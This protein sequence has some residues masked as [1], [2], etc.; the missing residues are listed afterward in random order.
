MRKGGLSK[1]NAGLLGKVHVSKEAA[2]IYGVRHKSLMP[3]GI[4]YI[5]VSYD[6]NLA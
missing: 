5:L 3:G 2:V 6:L 4:G 1:M